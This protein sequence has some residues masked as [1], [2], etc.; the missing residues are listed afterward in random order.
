MLNIF[1][2]T[3]GKK[4]LRLYRYDFTSCTL[5]LGHSKLKENLRNTLPID[6]HI[7]EYLSRFLVGKYCLLFLVWIWLIVGMRTTQKE[8]PMAM[9]N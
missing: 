9:P 1:L 8:K 7:I 6:I 2:G 3:N 5:A 4:W